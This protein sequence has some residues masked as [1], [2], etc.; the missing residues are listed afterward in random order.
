MET[1]EL[2]F[3]SGFVSIIG[4][5]NA[6]KSTFLNA[7]I[8]ENL[9]ITSRKP[10][11]TRY[12]LKGIYNDKDSQIIFVDTPG[13][14]KKKNKLDEFMDKSVEHS[15][16]DI[17]LLILIADINTY[18]DDNYDSINSILKKVK[19][20]TILLINKCD[21]YDGSLEEAKGEILKKFI[22]GFSFEKVI[23][24]SA[25]K[26]KNIDTALDEIKNCLNVG[27]LYYDREDITDEPEKKIIADMIRQQCL[28]KIDKEV[29]HGIV[30]LVD[31]MK[32]S[33]AKC[34]NIDATLVCE[35]ESHKAIIIGKNGSMIKNIGTGARIAIEKFIKEKVNLKINVIVRNNW[36][37][38]NTMLINYGYDI[39]AI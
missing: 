7:I 8:R 23:F 13:I 16:N 2:K 18:R 39:K 14:H 36:R 27:P 34:M 22:E 29:P 32:M 5:T 24:I 26:N 6:G 17:D 3:K 37:D 12:N 10:Q 21:A 38:E 28:Y 15:I 25:F 35:K 20:K 19:V 4:L 33:K 30:V 9:A 31:R 11:T 1:N